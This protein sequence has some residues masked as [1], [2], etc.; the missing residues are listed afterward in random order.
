LAA[1]VLPLFVGCEQWEPIP[2][3]EPVPAE[4]VFLMYDNINDDN[5]RP[6]TLNVNAAGRAVGEGALDADERVVVYERMSSGNVVYELVRDS[7][8]PGGFDKKERKK[9]VPGVH[10]SLDTETI[11]AV[12]GDVRALF[13]ENPDW[14][15]SFG[16]HGMGWIPKSNSVTISRREGVHFGATEHPFA[17]LWAERI[18]S[19]TRFFRGYGQNLDISEFV[20]ALGRWHWDFMILDDCFMASVETLYDMRTLADYI[21]ASPTEIMIEGFPYDRVVRTVFAEWSEAGFAGIGKEFVDYYAGRSGDVPCGTVAV[22]K[23]SEMDALA[24]T[25]RKL[26]LRT[27]ELVSAKDVEGIQFYE[28]FSTPAHVFY[29]LDDYL[30]RLRGTTTPADYNAF[31]AQL[32]RTVIYAGHT[33]EFYSAFPKG[34]HGSYIP[35]EHYSGL[36]VFIPWSG[37]IPLIDMYWQTDW[38][39]YVYAD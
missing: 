34:S 20:D 29:D 31:K 27:G 22:V 10:S 3:P 6:F 1:A 11:A 19:P 17:E 9:Y 28:G 4:R 8:N 38:Y 7:S 39:K 30:S 16:S 13:P 15:F 14:G 36:A 35:V 2:P 12:V 18:N 26:N 33:P 24:E 21:I 5:H 32:G 25:V 37:T 23:A